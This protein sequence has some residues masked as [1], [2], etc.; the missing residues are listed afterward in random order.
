VKCFSR[1]AKKLQDDKAKAL[2]ANETEA[3]KNITKQLVLTL[4]LLRAF[5]NICHAAS[6]FHAQL[7]YSINE[8]TSNIRDRGIDL[9]YDVKIRLKDVYDKS[10]VKFMEQVW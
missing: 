6:S 9:E 4:K 7:N 1:D 2:L 10:F 3:L 5:D 8:T